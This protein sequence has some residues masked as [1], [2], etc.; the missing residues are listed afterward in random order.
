MITN[1][2][3]LKKWRLLISIQATASNRSTTRHLKCQMWQ[4]HMPTW[5]V[6]SQLERFYFSVIYDY[7]FNN[8]GIINLTHSGFTCRFIYQGCKSVFLMLEL[9]HKISFKVV[10]LYI[11]FLP[12]IR[13]GL[14]VVVSA[15]FCVGQLSESFSEFT[16][17]DGKLWFNG[18]YLSFN[19]VVLQKVEKS[20][21]FYLE[22]FVSGWIYKAVTFLKSLRHVFEIY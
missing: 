1:Q 11:W 14:K 6:I 19:N 15:D 22:R 7:S 20:I 8:T 17:K 2:I 4:L 10:Y 9:F 16:F 12:W 3:W 21:T 13:F 5:K 18:Y